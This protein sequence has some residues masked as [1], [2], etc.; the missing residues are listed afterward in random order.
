VAGAWEEL[1]MLCLQSEENSLGLRSLALF[2]NLGSPR[3]GNGTVHSGRVFSLQCNQDNPSQVCLQVLG[4]DSPLLR[5]PSQLIVGCV[6]L[7]IK[8]DRYSQ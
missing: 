5:P 2:C 3:L 6:Q 4:L 1:A 7:K 8:S